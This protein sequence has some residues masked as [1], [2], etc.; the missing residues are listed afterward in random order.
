MNPFDIAWSLLK[1]VPW[2]TDNPIV[3]LSGFNSRCP[4]CNQEGMVKYYGTLVCTKCGYDSKKEE[5]AKANQHPL[6][7]NPFWIGNTEGVA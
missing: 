2:S 7:N 5:E 1:Q 3:F 6:Q 4:K